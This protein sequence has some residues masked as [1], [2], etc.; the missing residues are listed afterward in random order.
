MSWTAWVG[1]DLG[2]NRRGNGTRLMSEKEVTRTKRAI[3]KIDTLDS[4]LVSGRSC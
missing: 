3:M 2:V 1:K 4:C